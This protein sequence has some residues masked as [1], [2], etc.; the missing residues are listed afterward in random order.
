MPASPILTVGQSA[1]DAAP[2]WLKDAAIRAF[3]PSDKSVL[4]GGIGAVLALAAIALGIASLRR[5]WVG[6]VGLVAFGAIGVAAALTR[7]V[8]MPRDILPALAAT[9]VG[10]LTLAAMRSCVR[11]D[12]SATRRSGQRTARPPGWSTGV[13][14][15]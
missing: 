1:I 7:P 3:G 4:L 10:L 6:V 2:G 14:S 15:C 11:S 8:A 5:L 12:A 13:G 9:A